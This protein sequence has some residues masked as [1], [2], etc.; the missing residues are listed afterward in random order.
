[1]FDGWIRVILV[2]NR[3]EENASHLYRALILEA[4]DVSRF[5]CR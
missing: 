2:R 3:S 4:N 5:R 1:M